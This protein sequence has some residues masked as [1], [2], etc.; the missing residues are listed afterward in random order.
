MITG[1][2]RGLGA[3]IARRLWEEGASLVLVARTG[4]QLR[5]TAEGLPPR[6]GQRADVHVVDLEAFGAV[7]EAAGGAAAAAERLLESVGRDGPLDI[8]VNNA[9][10]QGPIGPLWEND[11]IE[12]TRAIAVDFL[13][14]AALCRAAIPRMRPGGAIVNVSGGGAA[15][16]RPRFSAYACAKTALVRLTEILAEEARPHGIRVNALAPGVMPTSMLA[17]IER[18][19]AAAGG[20]DFETARA[21]LQR[22]DPAA[23]AAP[24]ELCA[25]LVSDRAVSVTGR[26]ISAVWDP[27]RE[28][29]ATPPALEGTDLYTLRRV[30]PPSPGRP[31]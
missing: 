16:G 9:A 21:A 12:W 14:P 19:G 2:G 20:R 6:D 8:L 29:S 28:W 24:A 30:T 26:L 17:E 13:A 15:S 22:A 11:W 27:W 23:F 5:A 18:A 4:A 1:A 3:A 25:W 31:G 10:I 7:G